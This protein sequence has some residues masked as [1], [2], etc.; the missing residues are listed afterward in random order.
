MLSIDEMCCR[1]TGSQRGYEKALSLGK[2]NERVGG[3]LRCSVGLSTNRFLAKVAAG[4]K[5]PD[6]L[7][8]ITIRELPGKLFLLSLDDL[9]GI[10]KGSVP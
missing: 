2:E 7:T 4:M 6:G 3:S 5:K 1:L 10:G 8:A 9:P